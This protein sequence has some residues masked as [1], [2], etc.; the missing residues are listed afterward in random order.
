[1]ME[2]DCGL[3]Q[4]A[5]SLTFVYK[6]QNLRKYISDYKQAYQFYIDIPNAESIKRINDATEKLKTKIAH[7]TSKNNP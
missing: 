2:F 1:M 6:D 3:I 7:L 4:D 5:E